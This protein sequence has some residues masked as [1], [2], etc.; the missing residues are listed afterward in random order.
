[1]TRFRIAL[2]A[3]AFILALFLALGWASQSL[4]VG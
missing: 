4:V 2:I 3:G 1:M